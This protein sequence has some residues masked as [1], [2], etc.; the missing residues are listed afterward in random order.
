MI[1]FLEFNHVGSMPTYLP[2]GDDDN[3]RLLVRLEI[4]QGVRC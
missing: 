3:D 2:G 1:E 4:Q